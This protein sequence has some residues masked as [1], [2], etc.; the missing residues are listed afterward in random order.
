M[1]VK[2]HCQKERRKDTKSGFVFLYKFLY[3]IEV[4]VYKTLLRQ[5]IRQLVN[6]EYS[7]VLKDGMVALFMAVSWVFI[8]GLRKTMKILKN[9]CLLAKV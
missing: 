4:L 2:K 3:F 9:T 1:K 7:R 5:L 6:N 8:E